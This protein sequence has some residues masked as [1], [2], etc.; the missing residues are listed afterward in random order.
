VSV[1]VITDSSAVVPQVWVE[2]LPVDLVTLQLAW[3]DGSTLEHDP[4]YT[5][6][7]A[8]VLRRTPPTTAAPSPG[9]F[10]E[11]FERLLAEGHDI[12]TVTPPAEFSTT[13]SGAT[14]AARTIGSDRIRVVDARTAAAGPRIFA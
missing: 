2:S 4:P 3:R 1:R 9:A 5:E 6:V 12:L 7:S 10:A 13:F 8:G 11:L 14:L